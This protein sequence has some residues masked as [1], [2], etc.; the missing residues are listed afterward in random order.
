[1]T[2]WYKFRDWVFTLN[3][4]DPRKMK[5]ILE[6]EKLDISRIN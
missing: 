6:S 4:P 5:P 1:M 3:N 2:K